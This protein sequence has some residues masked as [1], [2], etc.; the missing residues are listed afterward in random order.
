MRH[1]VVMVTTSYPRFEGDHVGTFMEPIAKGIAAR[2]PRRPLRR[3][4]ASAPGAR[5]RRGR[6]VVPLLQVRAGACAERVRLRSRHAG[7]RRAAARRGRRGCHALPLAMTARRF[8]AMR[9]AQKRGA[10][11][12]HGHWVVPGGAIASA[13]RPSL[14]LVVSLHGSDVFVAERTTVARIA[15]QRV[16]DRSGAVT[17]CSRDL[18]DRAIALGADRAIAS[19][20]V[21]YGVDVARFKPSA[22]S[23]ARGVARR[24]GPRGADA[25]LF[26][27][28]R[29]VRKK[30]FE[31]LIDALSL[32]AAANVHLVIAGEGDLRAELEAARARR[33]RGGSHPLARQPSA[34]PGRRVVR[35]GGRRR[36]AVR[37]RRARQRGRS[38]E[39]AAGRPRHRYAACRHHGRRHRRGR[40]ARSRRAGRAGARRG[41]AGRGC[42]R[43]SAA[44]R[45]SPCAVAR[46]RRRERSW[47]RAIRL[48]A[49][50]PRRFEAAYD[51]ALA[52]K[53]LD[54]IRFTG[55]P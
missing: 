19:E 6:R 45:R 31:Y 20:V 52:F 4:V 26:T 13:A 49:R 37:P 36:R 16:F 50:R 32:V 10:T 8:K 40:R 1:V 17:A 42:D 18:A 5:T 48:G 25:L 2:G 28:G 38:A 24:A 29:L 44:G 43:S 14:P 46:T 55:F 9:V 12:M 30:G 7:G 53:S 33:R 3:A 35:R 15:A 47:T 27:A 22:R 51:R 39:H 41:R 34:R 11:V 21:P 54:P 23:D